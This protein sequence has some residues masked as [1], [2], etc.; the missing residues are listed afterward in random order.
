ME[1][2]VFDLLKNALQTIIAKIQEAKKTGD[3]KKWAQ[4]AGQ[5]LLD[6]GKMIITTIPRG[7]LLVLQ[8]VHMVSKS[9]LGWKMLW[10][11]LKYQFYGF[12]EALWGGLNKARNFTTSLLESMNVNGIF[13]EQIAESKRIG[14]RTADDTPAGCH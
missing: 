3:F 4:E 8:A 13:D 9:F 5:A 6:V 10:A 1:S 14:G 7:L 11:E 12:M 2:G